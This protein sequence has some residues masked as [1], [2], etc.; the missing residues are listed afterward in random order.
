[1]AKSKTTRE[2]L[3]TECGAQFPKWMGRCPSCNAWSSLEEK[4]STSTFS[5]QGL[6]VGTS[7]GNK[8][9]PSG[10]PIP[11]KEIQSSGAKRIHTGVTELDRVLGGGI[12]PGSFVLLGGDPGI[13]KS[14]LLLQTLIT[15]HDHNVSCLYVSGEESVEQIKV[16]AIRLGTL[17]TTLPV[18]C[19][20]NLTQILKVAE[21]YKPQVL[22]VDSIQT[23]FNPENSGV[24]GGE[25]QIKDSA[26]GLMLYAKSNQCAVMIVGHVTKGG[27]IAGPKVVEHMVDTVT[28]FEGEKHNIYRMLRS[29]KNRFGATYEV[30]IFEMADQGLVPIQNASELFVQN[31][32]DRDPGSVISCSLEGTRPILVEIQALVNRSSFS[33]A[34]RVSMGFDTKRLTIIL[35]LLEKFAGVEVGMHDVF[36]S[37]AGGLRI[38]DPASDLAIAAAI[39]S[40]HLNK[41]AIPGTLVLGELGLN[42]EIRPVSQLAQRIQEAVRMGFKRLV[43]P[44]TEK[45][46][47][48]TKTLEVLVVTNL[49][50][51]LNSI[52]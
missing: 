2:Y 32:Q 7:L 17:N 25:T 41:P 36:L 29:V 23:V 10:K 15:L 26:M 22:V 42:G 46:P 5:H 49:K 50:E 14:T 31:H 48:P 19:E 3:C 45:K 38:E 52:Y 33:N 8:D 18:L 28:Y 27:Q 43:I 39:A 9:N 34:Q 44:K 51:A 6:G 16:R 30:G 12:L 21:Q 1:M 11:L 24:P 40:N 47:K 4:I 13:G 37:I 20:T 35:A